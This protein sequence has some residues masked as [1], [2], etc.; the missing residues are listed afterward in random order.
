MDLAQ[1]FAYESGSVEVVEFS[2]PP[3]AEDQQPA[4][5][6]SYVI[7]KRPSGFLLCIPEGFLTQEELDL[8]QQPAEDSGIGPS[9]GVRVPPILLSPDGTW[10]AA[11][12]QE[13]V[14]AVVVDMADFMA[15]QLGTVDLTSPDLVPFRAGQPM[16]F[17]LAAEVLRFSRE[18]LARAGA[19]PDDRS[20]YHTAV[21]AAEPLNPQQKT[22]KPKRPTVQ[23]LAAQQSQM[24]QLMTSV[25]ERLDQLQ[26]PSAKS[27]SPQPAAPLAP[28]PTPPAPAQ[29]V[30]Q[31]P[32]SSIIPALGPVPR[33]LAQALGPPPPTRAQPQASPL[34]LDLDEQAAAAMGVGE[35]PG[36][37]TE[38]SITSAV[39]AQSQA[40]VALVSHLSAGSSDPLLEVPGQAT[41]IRGSVN[42]ARFQQEL[43]SRTGAFAQKIRDNMARRMDPTQMLQEDQVSF[44][45]YMERHGGYSSQPL[46]GLLA[47]QVAQALDLLAAGS[48]PGARDVLSLLLLMIEQTAQDG[49]SPSLGWLLTLQSEPPQSVFQQ[50]AHVPG[51]QLPVFSPLAEQRWITTALA[52]MKELESIGSRRAEASAKSP[53]LPKPPAKPPALPP[54]SA[55]PTGDQL[56]RKQQRAAQWAA[57]KAQGAEAQP[58]K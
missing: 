32:I 53:S 8:G 6:V 20:G 18:W 42:R 24:M 14:A 27:P 9:M 35:L 40:L 29:S 22:P 2:W 23:Q 26:N 21:S 56:T 38:G 46:L 54:P 57:R 5:C 11:P 33:E 17:P 15:D 51:A 34:Q 30:L 41:S 12:D 52:Y 55:P 47:W 45:R 4:Q 39:L 7:M 58:K 44:M 1:L 3:A 13:K 37:Q 25:V 31:Q 48:E 49:G 43:A 36:P 50:P 10:I 16:I 28:A 19:L